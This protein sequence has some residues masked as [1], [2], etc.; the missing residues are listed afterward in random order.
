MHARFFTGLALLAPLTGCAS[1]AASAPSHAADVADDA[2]NPIAAEVAHANAQLDRV[3]AI[4]DAR[5]TFEN[6]VEAL[7]DVIAE[8]FTTTRIRSF[9][10]NVSTDTDER[11]RGRAVSAAVGEWFSAFNK[12]RDLFAALNAVDAMA[13]DLDPEQAKLLETFLRDFRREGMELNDADS[14]RL[15]ALD[16]ELNEIGIEFRK[17]IADDET[18]LLVA[19]DELDGCDPEFL[20][21]LPRADE[22]YMI[23]TTG[24]NIRHIGTYC[25]NETTR[26]KMAAATGLRAGQKNVDVLERLIAL[27]L[28]KAQ[29]LGYTT[30]A[31][32]ETEPRMA[33]NAETVWEFYAELRPKLRKKAELD[34][35]EFEA[36]KREHLAD[37]DAQLNAWDV[38]FYK[39]WL[40]REKY[41]VDSEEVVQYFPI[42]AVMRGLFDITQHIY[43]VEYVD[44]SERARAEGR[45]M[46]HEDVRL[47]EVRDTQA[48]EL[49][50]EFYLDLHPRPGKYNHAAQFPLVLRKEWSNGTLD[51][52][53]VALVC[54][55]TKPTATKP[56]LLTHS[57]VETFFHEFGHC[58]HSIFT[59]ARFMSLAGTSVARDFVEAPSQMFENWVW[60]ADVL[61]GFARH[62]ETG[63]P[64]PAD[65][66]ERMIAAK[67]LGSGLN[68]EGQVYLGMMDFTYHTQTTPEVDTSAIR[69]QV[70]REA[71]LFEPLENSLSQASFGHLVG[72]Q[73][74]YYGYLWSLVYAA[75]MFSRFEADPMDPATGREYRD[76]VLSRGGTRDELDLVI[77]F[78]GREPTPD[79]F[80][81]ELGLSD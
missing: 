28:E 73:A 55:F 19:P 75:D 41:A 76:K 81:R 43:G 78:L 2:S 67:N 38:N 10:A 71:R 72:Y 59:T 66:I 35:A 79:A 30:T 62:Y 32:Y 80:L 57:E 7:D 8:F 52:P 9:L 15:A 29:L 21:A 37:P 11:D 51:R 18:T 39:N 46:W 44:V 53:L 22:L 74:G 17:N 36:A 45:P 65:L 6:T 40:L 4:D 3:A 77:D 24:P 47:F 64:L 50:G 63:A 42:D 49:L 16:L 48:D 31:D 33:K 20:A 26:L 27:R 1:P 25:T 34:F 12:R 23:R 14:A 56:S 60:N 61:G 5:R 13:L 58:L 69:R 70:Y 54:N 68:T